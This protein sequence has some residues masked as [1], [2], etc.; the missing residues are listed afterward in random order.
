MNLAANLTRQIWHP[1]SPNNSITNFIWWPRIGL[2]IKSKKANLFK[3]KLKQLNFILY[4]KNFLIWQ[5]GNTVYQT[6]CVLQTQIKCTLCQQIRFVFD[7][8][9]TEDEEASNI[10]DNE[11]HFPQ[12]FAQKVHTF[13]IDTKA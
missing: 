13:T 8:D 6:M 5:V 10:D 1:Y 3:G 2:N 7:D 9:G 12:K 11:K 4:A